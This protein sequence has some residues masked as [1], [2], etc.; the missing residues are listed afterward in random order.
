MIVKN[1]D[2]LLNFDKV[3][4]LRIICQLKV[5]K[6]CEIFW[7]EKDLSCVNKMIYFKR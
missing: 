1:N 3:K 4:N 6:I 5:W 7:K 2:A